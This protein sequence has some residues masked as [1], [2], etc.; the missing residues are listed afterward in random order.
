M[1]DS[2]VL[3]AIRMRQ[4]GGFRSNLLHTS[5]EQTGREEGTNLNAQLLMQ[6]L[7]SGIRSKSFQ[8]QGSHVWGGI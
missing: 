5:K 8:I 3:I 1:L 4:I 2:F 6:G 7:K